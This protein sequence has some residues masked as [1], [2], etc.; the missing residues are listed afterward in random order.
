MN[1]SI[2]TVSLVSQLK[3]IFVAIAKG[4]NPEAKRLRLMVILIVLVNVVIFGGIAIYNA[5]TDS[6]NQPQQ[7]NHYSNYSHNN[8]HHS[9]YKPHHYS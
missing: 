1:N 6:T 5:C 2:R 4:V 8:S 7:Y 9:N 3:D